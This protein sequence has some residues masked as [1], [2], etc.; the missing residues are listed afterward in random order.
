VRYVWLA[1]LVVSGAP[2]VLV[3]FVMNPLFLLIGGFQWWLGWMA[4]LR[5]VRWWIVFSAAVFALSL[6]IYVGRYL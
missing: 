6:V 5:P 4:R 2:L 3:G 1:I